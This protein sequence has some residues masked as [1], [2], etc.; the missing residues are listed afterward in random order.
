MKYDL[1]KDRGYT[2][3]SGICGYYNH[4]ASKIF[5]QQYEIRSYNDDDEYYLFTKYYTEDS[6]IRFDIYAI[7]LLRNAISKYIEWEKKATDESVKIHKELPNAL[8]ITD[9]AWCS[10]D[11]Q[12]LGNDLVVKFNFLSQSE[13]RHQ[14]VL[15]TNKVNATTSS[16]SGFESFN[17]DLYF[18]K[19]QVIE[20]QNAVSDEYLS[21]EKPKLQEDM[22]KLEKSKNAIDTF[23]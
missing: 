10:G 14:M 6:W 1:F 18:D 21:S 12:S 3:F 2:I 20:L 13:K 8:F 22:A 16:G 11:R 7:E 23:N 17:M 9:V 15:T 4:R 5:E 19:E